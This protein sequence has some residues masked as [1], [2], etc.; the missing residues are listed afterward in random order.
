MADVSIDTS[1]AGAVSWTVADEPMERGS[2]ALAADGR[3][4]LID[5]V[6]DEQAL[7]KALALGEPAGVVQ[8]LDRH[9]RDSEALAARYGVPH[10]RLPEALGDSPFELHRVL[11]VKG[12][13]E[14]ALWWPEHEL[15]LVPEAV[16]TATYFAAGRRAGI[17]PFL[18]L[19][20]PG[21]LRN[22]APRHLLCGHGPPLHENATAAL[23]EAVQSSRR[24][25]PRAALEGIRAFKPGG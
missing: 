18:R 7:A 16:G 6:D 11:W 15:L 10:L 9:P 1:F 20:P 22:F 2:H 19:K 13:R 5:P 3:V 8:L 17:H 14:I 4:W 25:M 12:W 23:T 21:V 24:D